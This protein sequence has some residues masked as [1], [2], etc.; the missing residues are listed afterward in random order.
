[1]IGL[2]D[3]KNLMPEY[4]IT[5]EIINALTHGVGVILSIVGLSWMLYISVAAADP[6]RIAASAIYGLTLIS[7]F[8]A[9]TVYHSM[10]ASR[11]RSIF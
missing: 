6:W 5:E 3:S 9:S 10:Y 2:M 7:L 4:S 8:L 11:H 1:M